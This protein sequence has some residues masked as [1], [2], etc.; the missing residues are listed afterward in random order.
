MNRRILVFPCGSEIGLEIHRSMRFSTHFEL[1]G[2]SSV[3]DH[4]RFVYEEYIPDIPFH[5]DEDFLRRIA[6]VVL[7][8]RIDAIYPTMDAVAET[9]HNIADDLQCLIIGSSAWTT[10]ICAS[11]KATYALLRDYLPTPYCH[12][13]LDTVTNYPIFIKPDRGYGSRSSLSGTY[14][15]QRDAPA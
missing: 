14:P 10:A 8:Y 1:I 12:E 6:E 13:R 2:A 9:L 4:G 5:Q 11:K 3:D 15:E 7:E